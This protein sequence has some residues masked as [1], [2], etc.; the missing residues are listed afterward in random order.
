MHGDWR[1]KPVDVN[2]SSQFVIHD[3]KKTAG[4]GCKWQNEHQQGATWRGTLRANRVT[5]LVGSVTFYSTGALKHQDK[6]IHLEKE[7]AR[8]E[9]QLELL[10][11]GFEQGQPIAEENNP[12]IL[13][14]E[15]RV[16]ECAALIAEVDKQT[17]AM[18]LYPKLKH[19]YL[20]DRKPSRDDI[21]LFIQVYNRELADIYWREQNS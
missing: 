2:F 7:C 3:V 17:F 14:L 5:S 13:E 21:F 6:L 16:K 18:S 10:S 12:V 20:L 11:Q 4:K 19:I 15:N 9:G 8:L 1:L